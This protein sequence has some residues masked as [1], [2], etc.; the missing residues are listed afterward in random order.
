MSVTYNTDVINDRLQVVIDAIDAG[1]GSGILQIGTAGMALVLATIVLS[2]PC[3]TIAGG[4]LT[5]S[6][7]PLTDAAADAT[8]TAA[9]AQITDSVGTVVISGLTVGTAGTDLIISTTSIASGDSVS[10]LSATITGN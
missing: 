1:V 8:G 9:E 5:F 6:N 3:A 7:L 4:V 2:D 10:L